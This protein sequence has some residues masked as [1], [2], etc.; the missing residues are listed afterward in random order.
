MGRGVALS[1]AAAPA[2]DRAPIPSP[3]A[4]NGSSICI[5]ILTALSIATVMVVL[6]LVD[7]A[8]WDR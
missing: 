5:L 2:A 6:Q 8:N 4:V 3:S 7:K 1:P